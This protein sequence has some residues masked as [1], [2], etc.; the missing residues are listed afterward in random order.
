LLAPGCAPK[1]SIQ[2][3]FPPAADLKVVNKPV[4]AP[5]ALG[6]EE[7]LD[8][9]DIAIETWGELGWKQVSRICRWAVANGAILA[10][11]S[12]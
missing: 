9:H 11:P 8:A 4:L 7:A 3:A 1:V 5:E 10:C 12:P 6:S 2:P